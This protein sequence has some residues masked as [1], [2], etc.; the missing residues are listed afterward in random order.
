MSMTTIVCI[1]VAILATAP[2]EDVQG[3]VIES[4]VK[5]LRSRNSSLQSLTCSYT[6]KVTPTRAFV[7]AYSRD[8][9]RD[10]GEVRDQFTTEARCQISETSAG[11][12]LY[13][14]VRDRP[15]GSSKRR[16]V[17]F[18]GKESWLMGNDVGKGEKEWGSWDIQIGGDVVKEYTTSAVVHR[19][20]GDALSPTRSSLADA[21]R[22]AKGREVLGREQV[23]EVPCLVIRWT[24]ESRNGSAL[25]STAWL[26]EQRG[27]VVRRYRL[28]QIRDQG[29][30][31]GLNEEWHA[32]GVASVSVAQGDG[33]GEYWYP[34]AMEVMVYNSEGEN[35]FKYDYKIELL[36]INKAVDARIFTPTVEDGSDIHDK[37][38]GKSWVFGNGPS[39]RLRKSIERRVSQARD[40]LQNAEATG[41]I[42]EQAS[43]GGFVDGLPW[44]AL[45]VG[46][47]GL[48]GA[49]GLAAR[50]FRA[51]A[52]DGRIR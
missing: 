45:A 42:G 15:D 11:R 10:V 19:Y 26:D 14:E 30:K 33:R 35:S 48:V 29:G 31:T 16:I 1:A 21:I 52:P 44:V 12:Y 9:H 41:P 3:D 22:A 36:G 38:T 20:L 6:L 23:D 39:P 27:L 43:P 28:E 2:Y 51:R 17:A 34:S 50:R 7:E 46:I 18:D 49:A 40:I 24:Q 37:R 47:M 4:V 25:R 32:L 8:R 5:Q 13:D